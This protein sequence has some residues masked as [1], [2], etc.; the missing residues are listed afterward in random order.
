M[1]RNSHRRHW[2]L[3]AILA[4]GVMALSGVL[5]AEAVINRPANIRRITSLATRFAGGPVHFSAVRLSLFFSPH[6]T[7][8]AVRGYL[9]GKFGATVREVSIYPSLTGLLSG[10]VPVGAI[11]LDSPDLYLELPQPAPPAPGS[12]SDADT[13]WTALLGAVKTMAAEAPGLE[14]TADNGRLTTSD[15]LLPGV[16]LESLKVRLSIPRGHLTAECRSALWQRLRV[17]ASMDADTLAVVSDVQIDGL[18]LA[19]AQRL[20]PGITST[21]IGQT[22]ASLHLHVE[23]TGPHSNSGTA[24]LSLPNLDIPLADGRLSLGGIQITG[25]WAATPGGTT[26]RLSRLHLDQPGVAAKARLVVA[27]SQTP[28]HPRFQVTAT[29]GSIDLGGMR[30]ALDAAM[31]RHPV[32]KTVLDIVRGGH[33]SDVAFAV[34]GDSPAA[35]GAFAAMTISGQVAAA[36]IHIPGIGL[37]LSDAGGKFLIRDGALYCN[38]ASAVT[39]RSRGSKGVLELGLTGDNDRFVLEMD[40]AAHLP[41]LPPVL[42]QILKTED[43]QWLN[44]ITVAAGEAT[45]HLSLGERLGDL[46]VSATAGDI[47]GK[48]HI[49]GLP[50]PVAVTADKATVT[51]EKIS[52]SGVAATMGGSAITGLSGQ[53]SFRNSTAE[54][55]IDGA[56]LDT[57]QL[58][59]VVA[60][61]PPMA[62]VGGFISTMSGMV[63]LRDIRWQG[64]TAPPQAG[65]LTFNAST[66]ELV[67]TSSLVP[68]AVTVTAKEV[69]IQPDSAA[70]TDAELVLSDARFNI[71]GDLLKDPDGLKAID[72][73]MSGQM[74]DKVFKG[75]ADG[76]RLPPQLIIRPPL[77]VDALT[78]AWQRDEHL[79][80]TAD[81][82]MADGPM[83]SVDVALA[84][85]DMNIRRLRISDASSD[86]TMTF[87]YRKM[88]V[89][90]SFEGKLLR[91]TVDQ[92]LAENTVLYG[93]VE[94]D[95]TATL[96]LENPGAFKLNGYLKGSGLQFPEWMDSP[97]QIHEIDV[98]TI[99]QQALINT[100]DATLLGTRIQ[101]SGKAGFLGDA[102][103][104][105]MTVNTDR[106]D[107]AQWM[108]A[109]TELEK[110][111][112][113]AP[114]ASDAPAPKRPIRASV[115]L[116]AK[117]VITGGLTWSPVEAAIT[118]SPESLN[119]VFT[120]ADTCGITLPG[121]VS[122]AKETVAAAFTPGARGQDL[123]ASLN[124]L[125]N[126]PVDLTGTYNLSG[127][128]TADG[129][130][131]DMVQIL[132]GEIQVETS[133]GVIYQAESLERIFSLLNIPGL[134][135]KNLRQ[136]DKQGLEYE[137]MSADIHI[138]EGVVA[139]EKGVIKGPLMQ[140]AFQGNI[141]IKDQALDVT[142]FVVP[143]K[144]IVS[145]TSKI[146]L[147]GRILDGDIISIPVK[148]SG[149]MKAPRY[150]PL[151]PDAVGQQAMRL[152]KD[153]LLLPVDIIQP[154]VPETGATAPKPPPPGQEK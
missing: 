138:G 32:V 139:L 30:S 108:A 74:G 33:A 124:C 73:R 1:T 31:G 140:M 15:A 120:R 28:E 37:A 58:F 47:T 53:L 84:Q 49:E 27:T 66:D 107:V 51:G 142:V 103:E 144:S 143:L 109:V 75:L 81:L 60:Q 61:Y 86:G 146:P 56:A 38:D 18:D 2:I 20:F 112:E 72:L 39:G 94:G 133:S 125:L 132:A 67:M 118:L 4:L 79:S 87:H 7:L 50:D 95:C 65:G 154:I 111:P 80:V 82:Q 122:V 88:E 93:A 123:N 70:I 45:G 89:A 152:L 62:P 117:E 115:A 83:V 10:G 21:R 9:P 78:V 134:I 22:N 68:G 121:S 57:A 24:D 40:V 141:G 55:A 153:I 114:N 92:L 77:N 101:A 5:I 29:A 148:I 54:T 110:A 36:D 113:T 136:Q 8:E 3:G 48:A 98:N 19:A 91:S 6:L 104:L 127:T 151:A 14:I 46:R 105:G 71:S 34:S 23:G 130:H 59:P 131:E 76:G 44:R 90:A 150:I 116:S 25:D 52:V 99:G 145:V 135:G 126:R 102:L 97:L 13:R 11:H 147:I 16:S 106:L 96:P 85:E 69:R 137:T 64:A 43:Q 12:A 63:R 129:P 41:D 119:M 149:T 100:I 17:A 26:V 42:A 35:L 128:V